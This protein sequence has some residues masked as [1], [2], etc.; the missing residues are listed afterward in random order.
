MKTTAPSLTIRRSSE[1]G[2]AD[3]G[4][5][6]S[7]HTFSFA[8]YYDPEHMGFR[9][10]R[11]INE[12]RV[13]PHGGFPEHPHRDMEIFSY[14]VAGRLAHRDSM[15][16]RRELE[17]GEIQLMSAG[18]G[19]TH[20]EFNPSA[21]EAAHFLQI[22]IQPRQRG[23]E[24]R[25]TE[26]KPEPARE[27]EAKVLLISPD[28]RD[29]SATIAQDAEVYRLRLTPG[30]TVS[31]RLADGRGAWIQ[32]IAGVLEAGGATLH[33]GDG[34]STESAGTLDFTA[35]GE[36]VEALLFDLG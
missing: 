3:H 23:L 25:Y 11:V 17:P 32:V 24:P 28:G 9:S 8:N 18:R 31:H 26:W 29:G 10:L 4:W 14:V 7:H 22:W 36:T 20:S 30:A 2:H 33:P 34:A 5:L 21:S 13:A 12:D 15:G 35:G 6:D 16:H 27:S 1:R 19:V